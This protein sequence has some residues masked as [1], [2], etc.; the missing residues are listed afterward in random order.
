MTLAKVA[1]IIETFKYLGIRFEKNKKRVLS[2]P[3]G[4][5]LHEGGFVAVGGGT[6]GEVEPVGAAGTALNEEFV[7]VGLEGALGSL[8]GDGTRSALGNLR[9]DG[10]L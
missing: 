10:S 3:L 4:L 8:R 9:S 7:E 1:I 5:G 2:H 6:D